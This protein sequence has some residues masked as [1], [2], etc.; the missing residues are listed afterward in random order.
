MVKP[1]AGLSLYANRIEALQDG[2]TAPLDS[3]ISNPGQVLAPRRSVQ[4]EIG[5]K[6]A[7]GPVFLGLAGYR[8][9]RPGDG[10]LPDGSFGY[11]G[12][13]RHQGIEF[14]V[15]GEL[16]DGLRLIGGAAYNDAELIGSNA[17]A[18]VPDFTAN[19]DVEWDLPFVPGLTL[20]GRAVYTGEQWADP[21]NT[22]E[23][24]AWTRFDLGARYV[25]V[26][27]E[28]PVTL[29]VGVDNVANERYWASAFDS[30]AIALLQGQPR[31]VKASISADF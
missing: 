25:F 12:D 30:F 17:V 29:R 15:N 13:Q 7:L 2:P 11:T 31:T 9:E 14:T 8:I 19:A 26:A 3:S 6:L 18:G 23:L 5:G 10:R 22:M 1:I 16:T 28:T 27:G 24:D 21:A 20:T 4:Y